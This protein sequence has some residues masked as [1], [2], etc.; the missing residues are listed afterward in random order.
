MTEEEPKRGRGRPPRELRGW[1]YD[2]H[3]HHMALYRRMQI[4]YNKEDRDAVD[5]AAEMI[6]AHI[7]EQR[8]K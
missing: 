4:A 3:D 1:T 5:A 7:N 6:I 8:G 2:D